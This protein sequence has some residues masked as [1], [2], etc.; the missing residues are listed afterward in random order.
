MYVNVYVPQPCFVFL[1]S[2]RALVLPSEEEEEKKFNRKPYT[3]HPQLLIPIELIFF[4]WYISDFCFSSWHERSNRVE[5][6][7]DENPVCCVHDAISV[8]LNGEEMWTGALEDFQGEIIGIMP[9]QRRT[10][11]FKAFKEN[12]CFQL[13]NCF[14]FLK[15]S[16]TILFA[17]FPEKQLWRVCTDELEIEACK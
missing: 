4:L 5:N 10:K 6:R 17:S 2:N 12:L 11:S 8:F 16:M 9:H 13:F 14:S 1:I 7:E 3:F 15:L